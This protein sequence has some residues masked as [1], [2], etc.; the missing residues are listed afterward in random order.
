MDSCKYH[1]LKPAD[2]HCEQCQ[3][4]VCDACV[5]HSIGGEAHCFHCNDLLIRRITEDNIEP[6]WHRLEKAFKYPLNAHALTMI[7]GL[8]VAWLIL[9]ALPLP[10]P[11]YLIL[12]LVL[13]GAIVNYN[14][15]CLVE[16]SEGNFEA[17][18]VGMAFQGTF[19][20]LWKLFLMFCLL[21]AG[22]HFIGSRTS[23][24]L[25]SVAALVVLI[26]LPA[27]LIIFAHT[28]SVLASANPAEFLKVITQIG[29][30]YGLL[31]I[32]LMIMMSSVGVIGQLIGHDLSVVSLFIQSLVTSYYSIVMFHLMGYMLYQ[33]QDRL[34]YS[35]VSDDEDSLPPMNAA[36]VALAHI[37]IR[38]KEGQYDRA[39]ELFRNAIRVSRHHE[40]IRTDYFKFLYRCE[41]KTGMENYADDYLKF[42]VS[43]KPTDQLG[44]DFKKIRQL[45]PSFLPKDPA[46]RF[47]IA[48][49]CY[50]S[51]DAVSAVELINGMHRLFPD[52]DRL[53]EVYQ[54]MKTALE[55]IP[56]MSAQAE[57]CM[58]LIEK[59]QQTR[60]RQTEQTSTPS[61]KAVFEVRKT[62]TT[63]SSQVAPE[64]PQQ[65][66]ARDGRSK[67]LAPLEFKL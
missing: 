55:R 64:D 39:D 21:A 67:D 43:R 63:Q 40:R 30:P 50:N 47:A 18:P 41:R 32:F 24:M 13:T 57:K 52:Y 11:G 58:A 14:F 56:N 16:T 12:S 51:G 65:A 19:K 46:V 54:L 59:L 2:Y 23:P 25:A 10:G 53:V 36:E 35:T 22:I 6:F 17:P 48:D 31:L 27:I 15:M 62:N 34:G 38:L 20:V 9:P 5:D 61:A 7:V 28:R 60:P 49:N 44:A 33:Y 3:I 29:M 26:G 37:R 8:S 42:Q 66:T 4:S 1:P 45:L